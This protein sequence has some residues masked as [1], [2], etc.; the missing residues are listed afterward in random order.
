MTVPSKKA[1]MTT[2]RKNSQVCLRLTDEDYAAILE[3]AAVSDCSVPEYAR[4][5]IRHGM[6]I[7]PESAK[8]PS[9]TQDQLGQI[10][11]LLLVVIGALS[12]DKVSDAK[13]L[14]ELT[15]LVNEHVQSSAQIANLLKS[16]IEAGNVTLEK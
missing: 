8:P 14:T 3:K 15:R 12:L 1:P 10:S 7:S 16:Q 4:M 6:D 13:S 5:L 2:N 11:K 9:S